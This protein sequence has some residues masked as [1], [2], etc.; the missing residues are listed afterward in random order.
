[1]PAR[2]ILLVAEVEAVMHPATARRS[3]VLLFMRHQA[4]LLWQ[5]DNAFDIRW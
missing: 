3:L 5:A 2:A 4:A 1:M